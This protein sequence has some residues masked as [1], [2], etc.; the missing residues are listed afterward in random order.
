[1]GKK[2]RSRRG[3][4]SEEHFE[5][6]VKD[7]IEGKTDR[8][9]AILGGAL[10]EG[11][12][13]DFVKSRIVDTTFQRSDS[14]FEYPRPLSSFAGIVSIAY[15]FGLIS[16]REFTAAS[17]IR[18]VRNMAAHTIGLGPDDF[19][20]ASD[21]VRRMMAKYFPAPY[22]KKLEADSS[23]ILKAIK[24]M[25]ENDSKEFYRIIFCDISMRIQKRR[26]EGERIKPPEDINIGTTF[27]AKARGR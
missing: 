13:Y 25:V 4:I 22:V 21:D 6:G 15:G 24:L 7:M 11:M 9:I 16:E 17:I 3:D 19:S 23:P 1:M 5:K 8:E 18:D 26:A 12:F 14:L 2:S 27:I 20:F 10:L